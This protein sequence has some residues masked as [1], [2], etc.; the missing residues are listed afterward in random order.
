MV[1]RVAIVGAGFMGQ[2]VHIPNFLKVENCKVVAL[3][4]KREK[5]G[6]SVAEK[7]RIPRFYN[8]HEKLIDLKDID[9]CVVVVADEL[10]APIAIDLLKSGKHVFVEKPMSTNLDDAK[11]MCSAAEKAGCI[12]MIAYM[13]R[14]DSGCRL[15]KKLLGDYA[16]R[17]KLGDITFVRVHCY[18]GDWICG[19]DKSIPYLKTEE[20]PPRVEPRPP[21]WLPME[22]Y[23]R[24]RAFN[25]IYCHDINLMR[26]FLGEPKEILFS[27]FKNGYHSSVLAYEDF[28][29]NLETGFIKAHFWDEEFKMYFENGWIEVNLPPP[30]LRNVPARVEVYEGGRGRVLR[31]H[32]AEWEWSF[33]RE[34]QHFINCIERG[35]EPLTSGKDS[36]N[37]VILVEGIY[38]KFLEESK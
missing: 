31:E 18:G 38:R 14:F 34:A 16:L 10:H 6:R 1:V 13:K 29:V 21:T 2:L 36:I 26:W 3:C 9:A 25:N 33:E 19:L 32:W 4:D 24:F 22:E 30:L 37:D 27:T 11:E 23:G 20:K 12:L 15:A 17:E 8:S 7:Y 35:K 28:N 5:L